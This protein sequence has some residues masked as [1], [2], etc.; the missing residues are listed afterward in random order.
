MKEKEQVQSNGVS[1]AIIIAIGI[2]LLLSA[3]GNMTKMI[4]SPVIDEV[5][6]EIESEFD[7]EF[8]AE[9]EREFEALEK[10]LEAVEKELETVDQELDG[11]EIKLEVEQR[12]P[13]TFEVKIEHEDV[14][15]VEPVDPVELEYGR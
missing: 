9:L 2:I 3:C 1:K 5:T 11:M 12:A 4:F 6:R 7:K 15:P 10:E 8:T 14:V 13:N